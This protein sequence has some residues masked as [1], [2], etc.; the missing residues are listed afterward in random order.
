MAKKIRCAVIGAGA[1]GLEHLASFKSHPDVEL[2]GVAEVHPQRRKEASEKYSIPGVEDYRDFLR[3]GSIDVVSVGLP[4]FLHTEVSI[5]ALK[6]GKNVMLD[7][8]MACSAREGKAIYDAWKASGKVFMIGQNFRFMRDTQMVKDYIARGVIGETYHGR[9]HWLRR[10][11]IPRIGSWFTQKKYAA[12]GCCYDIG[13]HYLD[14]VLHLMG[15]FDVEAVSGQTH[16][17]FGPRGR[18]DGDWGK[19][20]IDASRPFDVE[21]LAVAML[22]LKGGKSVLLEISWAI[23][24]DNGKEF[25]VDVYGTE[26]GASLFP[27]KIHKVDGSRY[28]TITPDFKTLPLPEDRILHFVDCVAKGAEPIVKPEESLKVQTVLDAIYESSASGREV[29]L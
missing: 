10:S 3:D 28:E 13:V 2:A 4:N 17:K 27:A 11:G 25:G 6:A 15:S 21:D 5:A 8:P 23:Q 24:A 26:G 19:G 16:A 1:I 22:K 18:G 9:A 7:K 14:M 20:E 12:G 29:R